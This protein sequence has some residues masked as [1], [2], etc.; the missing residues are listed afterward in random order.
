MQGR[1]SKLLEML[2]RVDAMLSAHPEFASL[3]GSPARAA[4]TATIG[5]LETHDAEQDHGTRAS[6]GE[7][8][9]QRALRQAL[10]VQMRGLAAAARLKLRKSPEFVEFKLPPSSAAVEKVLTAAKGMS[11]AAKRN[12]ATLLTAGLQPDFIA[13][14][15]TATDAVRSS[16]T[17]RAGHQGTRSNATA[18]LKALSSDVRHVL[19]VLDAVVLPIVHGE[20]GL[21]AEWKAAKR[22]GK[23]TGAPKATTQAGET[24]TGT[25]PTSTTP[26]VAAPTT[27]V[28]AHAA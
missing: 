27:E 22:L 23:K 9:R 3:S 5:D 25:T 13:Q 11:E 7:T 24:P 15:I 20:P 4:L 26:P 12:E 17:G 1:I 21:S 14:L 16:I 18:S 10:L 2:N 19:K 6:K 8:A 28:P